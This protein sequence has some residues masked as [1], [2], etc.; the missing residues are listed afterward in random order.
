MALKSIGM[1]SVSPGN[2]NL[3]DLLDAGADIGMF[4]EAGRACVE[5][6]KPF[7]YLLAT[8]KGRMADTAAIAGAAVE[9]KTPAAR[10][11]AGAI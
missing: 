3:K 10:M 4:V 1:A 8:V 6:K 5:N 9:Q 7:S 11:L 2:Q